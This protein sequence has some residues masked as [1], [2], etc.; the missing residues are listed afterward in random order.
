MNIVS[1]R[2]E[3]LSIIDS[4]QKVATF[5]EKSSVQIQQGW[6]FSEN[7]QLI[8][9]Y[10]TQRK[11][12]DSIGVLVFK[13]SECRQNEIFEDLKAIEDD[14]EEDSSRTKI[15][16]L[17]LICIALLMIVYLQCIVIIICL[18]TKSERVVT[19]ADKSDFTGK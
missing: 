3:Y 15:I 12:I 14:S 5:G 19:I 13:T 18:R 7:V 10:G 11:S 8:G 2:I 9:F 1:Q 17:V 16:V 6:T 4:K